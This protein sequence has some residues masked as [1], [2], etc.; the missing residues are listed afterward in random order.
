MTEI[1]DLESV[2]DIVVVAGDPQEKEQWLRQSAARR[3]CVSHDFLKAHFSGIVQAT[4]PVT[5][6]VFESWE[7]SVL[8]RLKFS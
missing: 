7:D 8:F 4:I 3:W 2:A 5:I 6:F 1:D